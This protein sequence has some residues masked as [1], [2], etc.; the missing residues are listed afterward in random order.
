M[1]LAVTPLMV[2]AAFTMVVPTPVLVAKPDPLIMATVGADEVHI[3]WLVRFWVLESLKVP[4]AWYC[5]LAP[6]ATF[7]P[8]VG[9]IATLVRVAFVT[10]N[11][12]VENTLPKTAPMVVVPWEMAL[13]HPAEPKTSLT[14]A[15]PGAV[16]I[17][18]TE[19]E[20]S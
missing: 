7:W 2:A 16:E 15:T 18:V 11:C 1:S 17:H 10:V 12:A 9:V 20:T 3:A 14:V 19:D 6:R 8:P 4:V 13:A 5:C